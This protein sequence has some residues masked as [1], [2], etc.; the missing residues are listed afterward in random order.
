M[1]TFSEGFPPSLETWSGGLE[2][3]RFKAMGVDVNSRDIILNSPNQWIHLTGIPL[4]LH[5]RK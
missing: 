1:W 2:T 4:V 3:R 5:S